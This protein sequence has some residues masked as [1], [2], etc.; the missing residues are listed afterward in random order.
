MSKT[1]TETELE[2]LGCGAAVL[3]FPA[4][5][6]YLSVLGGFAFAKL[7]EWFVSPTFEL[8]LLTIPVA[9]GV[10]L[11]FGALTGGNAYP[12]TETDEEGEPASLLRIY[13]KA[14]FWP[15]VSYG[16]LLSIGWIV[17]QFI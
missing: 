15:A 6:I 16:T 17:A 5:I 9:I 4:L 13:G 7:W 1:N 11:A 14:F 3:L 2:V 12:D 10:R 8:P